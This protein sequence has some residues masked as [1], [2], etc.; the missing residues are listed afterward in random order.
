MSSGPEVIV[1]GGGIIGCATAYELALRGAGVTLLERSE[2]AAGASGRN[3]GLL[4]CPLD[5]EMVPMAKE[6]FAAYDEIRDLAPVPIC[7]DPSPI[8]FLLATGDDPAERASGREEAEA[9]ATC[10]VVVEPLDREAMGG[11]EPAL[12]T[13]LAE[14]WLLEDARRVDPAALTVSYALMARAHGAD[15]RTHITTRALMTSGDRVLGVITDQGPI[16]ADHVIVS[17]GPWSAS[18]L[19]PLGIDLL[20]S[21]A[22]G[23]LVHLAPP[24]PVVSR[25]VGRAGWHVPPS[26]E[27][28]PP[29]LAADVAEG[30]PP[31][32]AGVLLQPNADGT[33]LVGGSRQRVV[34]AEP[35]DPGVPQRL[36]R[37]A[38]RLV[39]SLSEAAVLGAW[40]GIRPVTPDGRPVA[41][42][43]GESLTIATGHGSLGVILAAGTARLIAASLFDE[44]LPFDPEPFS[45]ARLR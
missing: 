31:A 17:A 12:A 6:T 33:L 45:P 11:L 9:A 22:R 8:G 23:W 35:E 30:N 39:P 26:P 27:P 21:G 38:I 5:P 42:A 36:L 4:V 14:G 40:W 25:L 34:T 20:V 32:D 37:E 19:R 7:L 41:G 44:P 28:S 18:L 24:T 13:D 43:L 1:V 15:V 29:L 2:L 16:R 10:G 3:H